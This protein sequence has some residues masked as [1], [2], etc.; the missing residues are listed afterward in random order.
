MST[1]NKYTFTPYEA[2]AIAEGFMVAESEEHLVAAWQYL[3][4]T[5]ICW[6]LQG[7]FGRPMQ[8]LTEQKE[9]KE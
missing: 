1:E 7:W 3:I 9:S 6:Q 5:G 2:I 4:H 8:D